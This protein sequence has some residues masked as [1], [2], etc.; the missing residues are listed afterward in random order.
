[1]RLKKPSIIS[2]GWVGDIIGYGLEHKEEIFDTMINCPHHKFLFLTKNPER[3][4]S[5][6]SFPDN[7]WVGVSA[8]NQHQFDEAVKYLEEVEATVK[9]ISFEPLL[10]RINV[11]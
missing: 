7:A 4:P 5:W 1:M 2:V 9:Y 8:T 11:D 6:G 3:L 10:E